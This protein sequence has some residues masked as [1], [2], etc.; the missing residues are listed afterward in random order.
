M[1]FG[2]AGY[3]PDV[4]SL[5]AMIKGTFNQ[6]ELDEPGIQTITIQND[7]VVKKAEDA[8]NMKEWP[9]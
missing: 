9:D 3:V 2:A 4:D 1:L 5:E 8:A 6:P 7:E